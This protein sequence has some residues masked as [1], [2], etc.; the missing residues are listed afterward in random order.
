M[1]TA[2][3]PVGAEVQPGSVERT[4]RAAPNGRFTATLL[5]LAGLFVVKLAVVWQL[6][7]HP[8]L[9]P[10]TG[11]DTTAYIELAQRVL[12]GDLG[13]G[14][15]LYYLSPLY[16]YFLAVVWGLS[17]SLTAVRV[18]QAALGTLSVACIFLTTNE[19]FGRR[20]AWIAAVLAA[21][22]GLFT[23]YETLILQAAIDPV[24]TS[25]GLLL[26][27]LALRRAWPGWS[28]LAGLVFGIQA[29][30]RPNVLLAMAALVA[31]LVVTRRVR[32][33]ALIAAGIAVA[34]L[35]VTIR[36]IVVSDQWALL[37]SQGGLNFY[38]GNS[39]EAQGFYH[40]IPGIRPDIA[41]Q[42][43]DAR[44]V[45]ERVTGRS[46]TDSEVSRYYAGRAWRWIVQ[47][48][49]D[50]LWLFARK[51]YYTF[52][53]RHIALPFSY[54]FFAHDMRTLLRVL[55]IGPWLIVPLGLVGLVLAAPST[56]RVEYALWAS[57]VPAYA[58]AVAAFFVAERYS[59]PLLVPLAIGS[60]AAVAA[61]ADAV[62]ARRV[63]IVV[64]A[65]A[66]V[67]ILG[68]AVD[69]PHGMDGGRSQDRIRMAERLA[70]L[71]R[72]DEAER[73]AALA[74]S[75]YSKPAYVHYRVGQQYLQ[76]GALDLALRHLQQ[77]HEIDPDQAR[78]E[79]ALGQALMRMDRHSEAIPHLRHAID[80]HVDVHLAGCALAE[81]L[82]KSGD[83][84]AAAKVLEQVEL[85]PDDDVKVWTLVG[86]FAA[87]IGAS[88]LA[89]HY[90]RGAIAMAPGD[91]TPRR[92][93]GLSLTRLRRFDD[94]AREL[95]AALRL[96][97]Q[98][99]DTLLSLAYVELELGRPTE[100]RA[101]LESALALKPDSDVAKRLLARLGE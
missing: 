94:A 63:R 96:E 34:I 64:A 15:G 53:A 48:P 47:H 18:L 71:G 29:L 23:F 42:A 20:A 25:S 14:P 88:A 85:S 93:L 38:I 16:S 3:Q 59:L 17:D 27:S 87:E 55:F 24:L 8:L 90:F 74:L 49:G 91:A 78:S 86:R 66:G 99:A 2:R 51:L 58:A 13:L 10:D 9:Q 73:W 30:N 76:A 57:F 43:V 56:H 39:G 65:V 60:G 36:N 89:E 54:P 26:L 52:S 21:L 22:T 33:A 31:L 77:A 92:E 45:A 6:K 72:T 1:D 80:L 19:W 97:P 41:G 46:L 50:A 37:S 11:L 4:A 82:H 84:A 61:L 98:N 101:H 32:R 68:V 70:L 100:A 69:W 35:P 28:V 81:A 40:I 12:A 62:R 79:F 67:V 5:P 7:D 95:A 44:T 75:T 83:D